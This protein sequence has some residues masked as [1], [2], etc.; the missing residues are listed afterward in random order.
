[1]IK[2]FI[3][4]LIPASML[5]AACSEDQ[6]SDS[7]FHISYSDNPEGLLR[8]FFF[9][10]MQDS[11]SFYEFGRPVADNDTSRKYGIRL[12]TGLSSEGNLDATYKQPSVMT[13]DRDSLTPASALLTSLHLSLPGSQAFWKFGP[14]KGQKEVK[15]INLII[16]NTVKPGILKI[17]VGATFS[18]SMI[19]T[20]GSIRV[21]K[22]IVPDKTITL[23]LN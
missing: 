20:S 22:T 17:Q 19:D 7:D 6:L 8:S 2:K 16:P 9:S 11:I 21:I 13:F 15:Q 14:K 10:N 1:M 23:K 3:L 18:K 5:L 4:F 12:S